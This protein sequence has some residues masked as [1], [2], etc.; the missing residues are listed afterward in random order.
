[1]RRFAAGGAEGPAG[2]G[3]G[4]LAGYLNLTEAQ[5][6]Q[7]EAIFSAARTA[8]EPLRGRLESAREAL[9]AAVKAGK[10]DAEIDAL[11]ASIGTISGQLTAIHS[12]AMVKFRAILTPEQITK[13]DSR[14][15]RRGPR[16]GQ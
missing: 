16:L 6:T 11:A 5:K 15:R 9:E 1:M 8:A 12:K 10:T 7:A 14:E 4:F 3:V 13:L 2:M